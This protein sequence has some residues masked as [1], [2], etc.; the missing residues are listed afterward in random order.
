MP[1]LRRRNRLGSLP[2]LNLPCSC[3]EAGSTDGQYCTLYHGDNVLSVA[4]L[5]GVFS[6][7][8]SLAS[9]SSGGLLWQSVLL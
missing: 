9:A 4:L 6:F 1:P 8:C 7:Q 5:G 3:D 2:I